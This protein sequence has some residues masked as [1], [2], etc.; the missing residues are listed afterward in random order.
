MTI[1]IEEA[2]RAL[3]DI[4]SITQRVRQ[5][6]IYRQAGRIIMLWGGL[7]FFANSLT[8]LAPAHGQMIWFAASLTGIAGTLGLRFLSGR[9][10]LDVRLLGAFALISAFGIL[11]T[12][13]LTHLPPRMLNVFWT[14]YYMLFYSLAGLWFGASFILIGFSVTA[15]TLVGFYFSGT[16]FDLWMAFVNGGGLILGGYWMRRN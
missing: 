1:G 12:A 2:A 9:A 13:G 6:Q 10:R 8:F 5:S 7:T 14:S 16:W 11:W 4:E 15:L 3:D